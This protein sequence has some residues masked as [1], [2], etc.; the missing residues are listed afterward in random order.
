ME[1]TVL[2]QA[3]GLR[4]LMAASGHAAAASVPAR[5]VAVINSA[6]DGA[7]ACAVTQELMA[8]LILKGQQVLLLNERGGPQSLPPQR[9]GRLVL[10]DAVPGPD[11]ALSPL[12][13]SADTVLVVFQATAA[14]I[15]QAYLC[16]KKLHAAQAPTP[17]WV[18]VEEAED[19]DQAN[20]ML[21]NLCAASARY[22]GIHLRRAGF[23][24]ADPLLAQARQLGLPV[25]QA[26][27]A[28]PAAQDFCQIAA[29]L[30]Q[31]P[32]PCTAA[33]ASVRA[34]QAALSGAH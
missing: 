30:L 22:L 34:G 11:G 3:D 12:A 26:F 20:R 23:V 31:W 24:R 32:Q 4:R 13:A 14:A 27:S 6:P 25:V 1:K 7:P 29:E 9:D 8:A 21:T 10:L 15:T 2:D 17:L 33:P 19:I 18:L 28:G 16:I 5:R